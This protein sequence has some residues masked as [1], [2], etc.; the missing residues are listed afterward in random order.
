MY[1]DNVKLVP[2]I[3]RV[4]VGKETLTTTINHSPSSIVRGFINM[5]PCLKT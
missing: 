4:C 2:G 1:V 5:Y 3:T